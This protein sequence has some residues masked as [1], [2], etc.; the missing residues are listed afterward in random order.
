MALKIIDKFTNKI[1]IPFRLIPREGLSAEKLAFS[2]TIGLIAG[3]FP[4][5][6]A[7]TLLS[8]LFT[9]LFRQ[10]LMVVQSVQWVMALAQILLIIPFMQF[11]AYILSAQALHINMDQINLAFQPGFFA[12]LKT[13]GIFHLY[14]ILTWTILS[15]PAGAI[16]YFALKAVFQKKGIAE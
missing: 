5:L 6:G 14:A 7:T 15:V 16:S 12:G 8:L 10:N 1:L 13:V 9:M 11:G 4:V 2:I 3:I